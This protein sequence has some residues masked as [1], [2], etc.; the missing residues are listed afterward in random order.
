[1]TVSIKSIRKPR[2]SIG[3]CLLV[4]LLTA[5]ATF[6]LMTET[7]RPTTAGYM[8]RVALS[9]QDPT[10]HDEVRLPFDFYNNA[11]C[12]PVRVNGSEPLTFLLDTGAT[13]S[14]IIERQARALGLDVKHE[15][16]GSFGTGEDE[17]KLSFA[18]GVMFDVAGMTVNP[19]AVAVVGLDIGPFLGHVVDGIAGAEFFKPYVVEIDYAGRQIVFHKAETY[20]YKG[21]GQIIPITLSDSRPYIK[22]WIEIAGVGRLE[23][24]FILDLGDSRAVSLNAPYVRKHS[25]LSPNRKTIKN[26]AYGIGGGA[27]ELLGRADT[28]EIGTFKVKRPVVAFS[29]AAKGSSATSSY[30][31]VIGTEIFRRFRVIFDYSRQR[32]ILEETP[33]LNEPFEVDMIGVRWIATG[34]NFKTVKLESVGE[35]SPAAEAGLLPGDLIEAIDGQKSAQ[36]SLD[37]IRQMFKIDGKDYSLEVKRGEQTLAVRVKTRRRI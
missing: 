12:I 35:G 14:F 3:R 23:G 11:V 4:A 18:K 20:A 22:A 33:A 9:E 21:T 25:I 10:P 6:A 37:E 28:F 17:T 27:P 29:T 26:T 1:M 7:V 16:E 15:V 8:T 2:Q 5:A 19:K 13:E 30:D 34:Q 31:G 36:L 32:L 24:K